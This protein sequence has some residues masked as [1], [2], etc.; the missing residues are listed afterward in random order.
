MGDEVQVVR[1]G[2]K[3]QQVGILVQASRKR[4]IIHME[5]VERGKA[6]GPTVHVGTHPSKVGITRPTLD[7][8]SKKILESKAKSQQGGQ[9]KG[10]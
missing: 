6:N 9:E 3:G 2:Y 8:D 5:R 4:H 7:K 1:G 10:K